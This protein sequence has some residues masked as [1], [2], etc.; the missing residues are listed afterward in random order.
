V[1]TRDQKDYSTIRGRRFFEHCHRRMQR[2]EQRRTRISGSDGCER[3]RNRIGIRREV[4][5]GMWAAVKSKDPHFIG[6]TSQYGI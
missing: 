3:A 1:L 5:D 6:R 4:F 2:I